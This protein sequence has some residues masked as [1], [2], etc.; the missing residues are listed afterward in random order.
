MAGGSLGSKLDLR[1]AEGRGEGRKCRG[2]GEVEKGEKKKKKQKK[3]KDRG[4]EW[5]RTFSTRTGANETSETDEA[6][7]CRGATGEG[8]RGH[9]HFR[10]GEEYQENAGRL[11]SIPLTLICSPQRVLFTLSF[12]G[13]F[14]DRCDVT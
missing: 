10:K 13:V 3:T 4:A 12:V 1:T 7:V 6:Q 14:H 8:R 2:E 11:R 9:A 5:L